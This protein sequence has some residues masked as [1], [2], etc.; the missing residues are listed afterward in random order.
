MRHRAATRVLA[1]LLAASFFAG[2]TGTSDL[3]ALLFHSGRPAVVASVPHVESGQAAGQDHSDHCMVGFRLANG[4]I[5]ASL[6]AAVR[7]AATS[8]HTGGQG[9]AVEPP[10]SRPAFQQRSRAPPLSLA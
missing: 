2:Q 10:A 1:A 5:A 7:F 9:R 4:Q 6:P 8:V 3:D